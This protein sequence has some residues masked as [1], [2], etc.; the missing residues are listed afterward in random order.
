MSLLTLESYRVDS[1][2]GSKLRLVTL[3]AVTAV[4]FVHA[5]N[6]T[7]RFGLGEN[8][9][10]ISGTPG[11]VGF[12]EYLISQALARW[13]VAMLFA[14]SGFLFFHNLQPRRDGPPAPC[15]APTPG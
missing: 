7:S 6:M 3:L 10:T 14:I 8:A 5:Y 2:L 9:A 15:R 13:P 1:R 12:I 11:A 4:A